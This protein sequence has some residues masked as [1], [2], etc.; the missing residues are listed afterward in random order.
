MKIIYSCHLFTAMLCVATAAGCDAANA[1]GEGDQTAA[2]QEDNVRN[3]SSV[4]LNHNQSFDGKG[5]S[6]KG[7]KGPHIFALEGFHAG[8]SN[9]YV[10]DNRNAQV[11]AFDIGDGRF[12]YLDNAT[13][14]NAGPGAVRMHGR[15]GNGLARLENVTAEQITG[16]GV[17]IGSSVHEVRATSIYM[18]GMIDYSGGRGLPRA[19]TVGWRQKT[20]TERNIAVGGHQIS[21]TNMISSDIGYWLTDAQLTSFSQSIADANR[22]YGLIIDGDSDEIIFDDLFCAFNR[23]IKIAGN[24][25]NV[26]LTN[27]RTKN[28][29]EIP[30]W[31][32][33]N[34]YGNVKKFYDIT[35]EDKAQIIIDGNSW[36][37]NKRVSVAP[38]ANLTVTGGIYYRGQSGSTVLNGATAYLSERG[39]V[40]NPNEA[41]W[42]AADNGYLF[43]MEYS[44]DNAPGVGQNYTV[45]VQVN[46]VDTSLK[47]TIS[48]TGNFFLKSYGPI[49]VKEGD[50]IG[51]KIVTSKGSNYMANHTVNIQQLPM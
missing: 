4:R 50:R 25:T 21:K 15:N 22:G 12:Q 20:P 38:S 6:V 3:L 49:E 43:S 27:L 51:A 31:G 18:A 44:V 36:R 35:V 28:I 46:G 11:A 26:R 7:E 17:F 39:A 37:G 30:P 34:W 41:L 5:Y 47:G 32:Q 13:I 19:G 10:A 9:I 42:R 45:T 23:G 48:G 24:S 16:T 33:S 40:A 8:V 2:T 14:V 29:G 1:D